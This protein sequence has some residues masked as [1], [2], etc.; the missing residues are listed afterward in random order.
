MPTERLL[1]YCQHARIVKLITPF[2]LRL[3]GGILI[4]LTFASL[5]KPECRARRIRHFSDLV[6]IKSLAEAKLPQEIR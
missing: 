2:E 1:H 3:V 4:D 6:S 5:Y